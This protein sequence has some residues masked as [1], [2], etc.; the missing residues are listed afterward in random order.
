MYS[1]GFKNFTK[2]GLNTA[3]IFANPG[4]VPKYAILG[5]LALYLAYQSYFYG[6][7]ISYISYS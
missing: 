7:N 5:G 6:T 2:G 4:G 3:K 1:K